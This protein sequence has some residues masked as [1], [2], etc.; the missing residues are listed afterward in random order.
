MPDP[1]ALVVTKPSTTYCEVCRI[2][3]SAVLYLLSQ[4][5]PIFHQ[6]QIGQI[7]TGTIK[8]IEREEKREEQQRTGEEE[9]QQKDAEQVSNDHYHPSPIYDPTHKE[10]ALPICD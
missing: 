10:D 8:E 3:A 9:R 6:S 2:L 4:F 5:Y 7:R 1:P